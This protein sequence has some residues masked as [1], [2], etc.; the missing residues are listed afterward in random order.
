[1]LWR[2]VNVRGAGSRYALRIGIIVENLHAVERP[3]VTTNQR[4]IPATYMRGGTSKGVFFHSRD[5]PPAGPERDELLLRI[6][7]APD[8]LQIDGMG[9]TYSST[10]TVMVIDEVRNTEVTYWFGQVSIDE[11]YIDWDGN[12]GN[13]TAA[14]GPFAVEEGLIPAHEPVTTFTLHNGNTDTKIE[15]SVPVKNE[16]FQVEGKHA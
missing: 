10:R 2:N 3:R 16:T 6:M 11:A 14:V 9:G 13:L 4:A 15:T 8:P 1:M 5:L 12:C 7:G